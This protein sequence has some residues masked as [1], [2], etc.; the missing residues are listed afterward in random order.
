MQYTSSSFAESLVGIFSW[1]LRPHVR[2][3]SPAGLF[4]A[5][6]A[7]ESHVADTVLERAI[8]PASRATARVLSWFRWVQ[9]GS[10]HLYLLY[11]LA[12]LL[13]LLLVRR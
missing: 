2:L 5:P 13:L 12:A 11:V 4:P 1:A 10:V 9:R 6:G 3:A 7:F 8:L